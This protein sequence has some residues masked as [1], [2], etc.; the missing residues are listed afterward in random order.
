MGRLWR[1]ESVYDDASGTLLHIYKPSTGGRAALMELRLT[2]VDPSVG[3]AVDCVVE[4]EPDT[5]WSEVRQEILAV[6]G[7]AS[8]RL[9]AGAELIDD[10]TIIGMPPLLHGSVVT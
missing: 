8:G 10:T 1:T 5:A 9:F 3:L 4:T 7:R 6:V 2:V